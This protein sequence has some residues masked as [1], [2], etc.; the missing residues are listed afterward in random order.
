MGPPA[1]VVCY[2]LAM[3]ARIVSATDDHLDEA[4]A[5][6]RAGEVV[7]VPTETVY[8]LAARACDEAAVARV[9]ASKE[10]PRFDPLIVHVAPFAL[11]DVVGRLAALGL[12]DE[13]ALS[14]AARERVSSL[15]RAFW[16]G[17]LTLVLPKGPAVP[18][19]VTS[20]LGSVAVRMPRHE[21]AQRLIARTGPLAAP[22][23]NRFGRVSP[24]SAEDVLAELGERIALIVDGGRCE[25]GVES[26]V[27]SVER[28]GEGT[29]LRPGGTPREEIE[30]VFGSA[31]S[32]PAPSM[33]P[34][35]KEGEGAQTSPG[36]LASHY[37]PDKRL[38][39]L[40]GRATELGPSLLPSELAPTAPVGLLCQA[41]DEA[42]IAEA[43]SRRLGREVVVRVLSRAGDL[44]E[45]ARHLFASLRALDAS[46][47]VLL[48][49][50]L[51][52]DER[53]LAHAIAD[54]LRRAAA[55]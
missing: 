41:G 48:Y 45:A 2:G 50:E 51:P 49:A 29:L 27:V 24:T 21:V 20:G 42:R 1:R 5:L 19:L 6:L 18:E 15:A 52:E 10:R 28:D 17:P 7:A 47:A 30:R 55:R 54:R 11:D 4:A 23:A 14:E 44:I 25:V 16:P 33:K 36:M 34:P 43:V 12:V 38:V 40:P 32:L 9:F 26:S 37:A 8:G 22:S 13:A 46:A 31:L 53:G 39:L 3:R 35:E